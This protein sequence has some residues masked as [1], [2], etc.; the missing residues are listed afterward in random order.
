MAEP[1]SALDV[2]DAGPPSRRRFFT[3]LAAAAS[4]LIGLAIGGPLTALAL[5]PLRKGKAG[6]GAR[7]DL[8]PLKDVGDEPHE[9]VYPITLEDGYMTRKAKAR[10]YLVKDPAAPSGLAVLDTTCTHLGCGVSWSAER[11]A[12]LC[13]CHGGVYAADGTVKGGPPPRPLARLP[14]TVEAGRVSLDVGK[15]A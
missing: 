12:F 11:K 15:L 8:G 1:D 13:P 4:A 3:A 5:A 2:D 6:E 7:V 10:V 14:F 9:V